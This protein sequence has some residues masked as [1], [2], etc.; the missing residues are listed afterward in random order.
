MNIFKV[1]MLVAVTLV[2]IGSSAASVITCS[3]DNVT[4]SAIT[5]L[6]NKSTNLLS[7]GYNASSCVGVYSGN[8]DGSANMPTD[9][10]GELNDGMLNG[11][12]DLFDGMEFID[13]EDLQDIAG[14]D[15]VNDPGWIHLANFQNDNK[16]TI[17]SNV[18]N[19]ALDISQ[20]L[21]ISF[22]CASSCTSGTWKLTTKLDIIEQVQ[23]VL[24]KASFDHLAISIKAGNAFAVYDF[25][26]KDIFEEE[27]SAALNFTTPYEFIGG[28]NTNDFL[29][30]N[31]KAQSVSHINVWARDPIDPSVNVPE[32]MSLLLFGIALI[33]AGFI[34]RR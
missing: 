1:C 2:Y 28:F 7:T 19:G 6:D 32:P 14:G 3:T 34:R 5:T 11:A 30:K 23:A 13:P 8:D 24:G 21:N 22:D 26:F 4:L 20:L 12:G 27:A 9:N 29:N 33:A 16:S 17:Y 15:G 31:G 10:V 25:D 18:L